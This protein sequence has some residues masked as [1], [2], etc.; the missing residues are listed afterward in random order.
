MQNS[1]RWIRR[2]FCSDNIKANYPGKESFSDLINS[3]KTDVKHVDDVMIVDT[4]TDIEVEMT[5]L[6]LKDKEKHSILHLAKKYKISKLRAKAIINV[7]LH[8]LKK[9]GKLTTNPELDESIYQGNDSFESIGINEP[10]EAKDDY[11][12]RD[13]LFMYLQDDQDISE[14]LKPQMLNRKKLPSSDVENYY[15]VLKTQK[16]LAEKNK[17]VTELPNFSAFKKDRPDAKWKIAIKEL[18]PSLAADTPLMIRDYDGTLRPATP[19]EASSR[20]WVKKPR[21]IDVLE[22]FQDA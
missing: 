7:R 3:N 17:K 19:E 18:S 1:F 15:E 21:A 12:A 20:T 4:P 13:P 22:K 5:Q 11:V 9:T 10:L 16:K 6:Y 2:S 8:E 14:M